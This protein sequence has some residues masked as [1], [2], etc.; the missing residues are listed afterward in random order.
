MREIQGGFPE[1]VMF[2]LD[3]GGVGLLGGGGRRG[4]GF[5]GRGRSVP[6]HWVG[7][8]VSVGKR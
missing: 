6:R 8:R 5:L 4:A 1:V 3:V 2:E 7:I